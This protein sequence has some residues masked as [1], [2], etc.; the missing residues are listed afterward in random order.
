MREEVVMEIADIVLKR[1]NYFIFTFARGKLEVE[2]G[3]YDIFK[4]VN[5]LQCRKF[6]YLHISDVIGQLITVVF[7][8]NIIKELKSLI[9]DEYYEL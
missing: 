9:C 6:D 5:L 3:V 4:V 2:A 1:P 8:D 7:V